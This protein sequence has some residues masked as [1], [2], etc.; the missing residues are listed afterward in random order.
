MKEH[1]DALTANKLAS[2]AFNAVN[3]TVVGKAKK[4]RFKRYGEITSLEGKDN[5]SGIRWRQD[6]V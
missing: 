4:V 2:R 1:I 3:L 6:H 5:S